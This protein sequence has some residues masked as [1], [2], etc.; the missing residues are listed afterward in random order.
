MRI[1]FS[2]SLLTLLSCV[3]SVKVVTQKPSVL[4]EQKGQSVTLDCNVEK[5]HDYV[6]WYKQTPNTAP[7]FVLRF[8]H[9][10]NSPNLYGDGFTSSHFTSR[11]QQSNI[12]YS[13][14]IS[15]VDVADSAV[16]YCGTWY[17]SVSEYVFGQGTQLIV[18]D[19]ADAAPPV[20]NIL[21]PSREEL[22]SSSKVTLVCLINDMSVAFSDVRWLVNKNSVTK[23]V[24]TGS[25]DQQPDKKFK[26]SS[27]LTI[28]SSEWDKVEDLTC[29]ASVASK[30]TSTTIKKSDC[31][32]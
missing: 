7:Q 17:G 26:M 9:S 5:D 3:G 1:I 28:E 20:L 8:Y 15:N 12:D 18:T 31:S 25:A 19:A 30:T 13:L 16:Y 2:F 4:T 6:S 21:R 11:A 10:H 24:F 23:G 22:I 27:Y 14:I 29:E 32:D